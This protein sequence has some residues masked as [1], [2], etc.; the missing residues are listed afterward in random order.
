MNKKDVEFQVVIG[1]KACPIYNSKNY[2]KAGCV[3][4]SG[5]CS[6]NKCP[7]DFDKKFKQEAEYKGV[8]V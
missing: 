7:Y 1:N 6:K 5:K 2:K 8:E 4:A 3:L